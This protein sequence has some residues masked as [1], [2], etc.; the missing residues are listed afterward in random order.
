[1]NAIEM[2]TAMLQ[3]ISGIDESQVVLIEKLSKTIRRILAAAKKEPVITRED[4]VIT[5]FVASIGEGITPLPADFNEKEAK[6]KYL[7]EKYG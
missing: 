5:P 3:D 7:L 6:E 2:K 1:M 4:L